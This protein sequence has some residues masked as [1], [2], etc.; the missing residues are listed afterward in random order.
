MRF[1][2][3]PQYTSGWTPV[4]CVLTNEKRQWLEHQSG[5]MFGWR[6]PDVLL[7]ERPQDATMFIMRWS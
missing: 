1:Q 6:A 3:Y 7:F 2:C 5:G 4:Q